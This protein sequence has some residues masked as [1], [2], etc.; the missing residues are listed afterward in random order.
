MSGIT[1]CSRN[2]LFQSSSGLSTGC[3]SLQRFFSD[4]VA[5][6]SILIRSK[7]RMQLV[8]CESE[9]S[10]VGL[11]SI[12]IRSKDRMQPRVSSSRHRRI[13][14]FNPHLAFRPDATGLTSGACLRTTGFNPHLAFRPDATGLTS[15]ACLRT[16]GFN[17]HLAFRPDATGLTSGACL[18]TTGFN[19]HLAFRPDATP[20]GCRANR[21]RLVSILIRSFDRM[22]PTG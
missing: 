7:D 16:T 14:G 19:P 10:E 8:F 15:G 3:D 11:V 17:P 22:Q 9:R 6:V 5:V 12:L 1:S 13:L 18:R 2:S 20:A 21:N 4:P